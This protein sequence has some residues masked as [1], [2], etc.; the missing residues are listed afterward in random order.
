MG[1][2]F[3]ANPLLGIIQNAAVTLQL[4]IDQNDGLLWNVIPRYGYGY[5][6]AWLFALGG[7]LA[8]VFFHEFRSARGK[9]FLFAWLVAALSIGLAQSVNINRINLIFLPLIFCSGACLLF[10]GRLWKPLMIFCI[11]GYGVGF[12]AFAHS[13]FGE[14]YRSDMRNQ[15]FW[16]ILPALQAARSSGQGPICVT[17]S[18][19]Q[20][21]IYVLAV[22]QTDPHV[23]LPTIVYDDP[24]AEIRT[25]RS[26]G[27]YSFGAN[28]CPASAD[29]IYVFQDE[30]PPENNRPY[31]QQS[32]GLYT[33]YAPQ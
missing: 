16:G 31:L 14:Q 23:F 10:L 11:L 2:I 4:L 22:E 29:T 25:V 24:L 28:R 6:L 9:W 5:P 3:S 15:F 20:P 30:R 27:R 12:A 8:L 19:N 21:Y 33:V 18:I 17:D 1:V 13:Y 32:F 7:V 26:M